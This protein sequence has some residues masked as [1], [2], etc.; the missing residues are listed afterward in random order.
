ML[1]SQIV[2][3]VKVNVPILL[4]FAAIST[5]KGET[6]SAVSPG[7]CITVTVC[8]VA[9]VGENTTAAVRVDV[10]G[11]ALALRIRFSLLLPEA[12][13][14]VSHV[15]SELATHVVLEVT[16]SVT[17]PVSYTHLRAHET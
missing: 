10:V 15:L 3:E 17:V 2:F 5:T 6:S 1:T 12:G 4:A 7:A 11:F 13:L 9:S 16:F 8:S 14:I